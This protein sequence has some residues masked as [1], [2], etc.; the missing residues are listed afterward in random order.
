MNDN[1]NSQVRQRERKRERSIVISGDWGKIKQRESKLW[2]T[3][4]DHK[5][6]EEEAVL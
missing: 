4:K 5:I 3:D 6:R 1:V 2:R